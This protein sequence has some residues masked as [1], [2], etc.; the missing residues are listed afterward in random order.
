MKA[1]HQNREKEQDAKD[2]TADDMENYRN[3][4]EKPKP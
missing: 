4:P 1:R 2:K 3:T